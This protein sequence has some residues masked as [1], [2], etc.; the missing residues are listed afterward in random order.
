MAMAGDKTS[1]TEPQIQ[2]PADEKLSASTGGDVTTAT[3]WR[4]CWDPTHQRYYFWNINTGATTWENPLESQ[5]DINKQEDRTKQKNEGEETVSSHTT[6]KENTT[7]TRL[8]HEQDQGVG[9]VR[10]VEEEAAIDALFDRVDRVK[11]KRL[12]DET[13]DPRSTGITAE[14]IDPDEDTHDP[15]AYYSTTYAYQDP[16]YTS[17]GRINKRTGQVQT[18]EADHT[19]YAA[20]MKRQCGVY[21]DYDKFV[22]E[23][24]VNAG[25]VQMKGKELRQAIK[26][27]QERK[28]YNKKRWLL[29]ME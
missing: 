17:H 27:K 3:D 13:L 29:E 24:G 10:T 25:K 22:A 9:I 26:K 11:R 28:A 19:S 5:K 8:Y 18:F 14:D 1:R 4:A 12:A 20:R 15:Y 21:F 2:L 16:N 23:R 6:D 7:E